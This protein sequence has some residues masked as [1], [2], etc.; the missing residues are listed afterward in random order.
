[1]DTSFRDDVVG[2]RLDVGCP[3]LQ[4]IDFNASFRVEMHMQCPNG[5]VVTAMHDMSK[6]FCEITSGMVE[7]VNE[8]GH[9]VARLS[10]VFGGLS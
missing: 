8:G 7:R 3:A 9:T 1:M 4:D 6:L 2:K 10:D 5:H